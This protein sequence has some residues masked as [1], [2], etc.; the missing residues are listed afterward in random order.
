MIPAGST[1]WPL[2]VYPWPLCCAPFSAS[3]PILGTC[4][5]CFSF[6]RHELTSS[7]EPLTRNVIVENSIRVQIQCNPYSSTK[8]PLLGQIITYSRVKGL[9]V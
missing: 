3:L 1:R 2:Y 8:T 7:W 5:G 4:F 6:S 9:Y